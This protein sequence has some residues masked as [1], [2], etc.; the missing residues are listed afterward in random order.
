MALYV[1]DGSFEGLLCAIF[2]SYKGPTPSAIVD[3]RYQTSLFD[4]VLPI[5]T[6]DTIAERVLL[7]IDKVSDGQASGKCFKI[8]QSE[9]EEAPLLIYRL[10]KQLMQVKRRDFFSRYANQDVLRAAQIIKMM[11]REIHRM[12]AFVRFQKLHDGQYCALIEP[13]FNVLPFLDDHFVRRFADMHWRIFDVRR[14]YGIE[15]D[16]QVVRLIT[17]LSELDVECAQLHED[18]LDE[19]EKAFQGLWQQYFHSVNIQS[20]NNEKHHV[21]QL[22]KRYWK[23]LSEKQTIKPEDWVDINLRGK[24]APT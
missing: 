2:H 18:C 13:D 16:G 7:G 6:D 12:H 8:F 23:Y 3:D 24:H 10:I 15:Y 21:H 17:Q 1:T 11:G 20:R 9:L 19:Y 4:D 5:A 22:P 14:H